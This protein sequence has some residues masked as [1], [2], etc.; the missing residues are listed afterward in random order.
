MKF[1]V[2]IYDL[3]GKLLGTR[4]WSCVGCGWRHAPR[5]TPACLRKGNKDGVIVKEN[6]SFTKIKKKVEK[7]MK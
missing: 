4:L 1:C 7:E 2:C 6:P 3:D 5:D